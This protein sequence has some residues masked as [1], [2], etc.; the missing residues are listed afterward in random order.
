MFFETKDLELHPIEF[1]EKFDPGVID[2]GPEYR[3][4]TPIQTKGRADLVE[5]HHGKHKV[6][7]DIRIQGELVTSL[8]LNCA[9]CLEPVK[10]HVTRQFDLLYRPLGADAGR[11]EMSITDAEAE[12]SYYEGEGILLDDVVREQVLLAAPL[13]VT[14]RENCKGLCAHCGKNLNEG[15][16]DC[17]VE[18]E[19]P[20]WDALKEIRGKL[21]H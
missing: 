13:K 17:N 21:A 11:D 20:R 19:E 15:P 4:R 7:Q 16:C 14:C 5:E 10:Q 9:R 3:Q 6:I 2:L 12:I 18:I 8:E 1:S